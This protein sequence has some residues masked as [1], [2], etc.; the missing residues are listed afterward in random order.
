MDLICVAGADSSTQGGI[1]KTAATKYDLD[2]GQVS[3][4]S[5]GAVSGTENIAG[6]GD[7]LNYRMPYTWHNT[8]QGASQQTAPFRDDAT[9]AFDTTS[10]STHRTYVG[11]MSTKPFGNGMRIF[12]LTRGGPVRPQYSDYTPRDVAAES[13]NTFT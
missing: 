1:I 6:N 12:L 5:N 2:S 11:M 7:K 8:K 4:L 3:T 9:D 10:N 13:D